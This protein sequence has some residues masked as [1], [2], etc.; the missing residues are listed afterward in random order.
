MAESSATLQLLE[1]NVRV[2]GYPPATHKSARQPLENPSLSDFGDLAT[3]NEFRSRGT[4]MAEKFT[5]IAML[6]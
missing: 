2:A 3:S 5:I 4:A 6:S 1:G